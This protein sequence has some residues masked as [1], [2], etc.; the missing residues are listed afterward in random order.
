MKRSRPWLSRDSLAKALGTVAV[1][2]GPLGIAGFAMDAHDIRGPESF[3][4]GPGGNIFVSSYADRAVY[5]VGPAGAV[6]MWFRMDEVPIA[7][8]EKRNPRN[9]P[10]GLAVDPAAGKL[11]VAVRPMAGGAII[12]ANLTG[13]PEPRIWRRGLGEVNGLCLA[14]RRNEMFVTDSGW[15]LLSGAKGRLLRCSLSSSDIDEHQVVRTMRFPN[16]VAW[17][18]EEDALLVTQTYRW[19]PWSKGRLI[20]IDLATGSS[21]DTPLGGWPDGV[22]WDPRSRRAYVSLQRDGCVAVFRSDLMLEQCV[23]L[24]DSHPGAAPSAAYAL[25][26]KTLVY[27]DLWKP[28]VPAIFWHGLTGS[29]SLFRRGIHRHPFAHHD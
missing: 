3:A 25:H 7:K 1:L 27:S 20:R 8:G 6:E 15:P 22:T 21:C 10:L 18:P 17:L 28:S 29:E 16:G 12:E 2:L 13:A 19:G 23:N 11:Y 24:R 14:K 26:N 4:L 5:R 9:R